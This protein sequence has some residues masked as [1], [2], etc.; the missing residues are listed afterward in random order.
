MDNILSDKITDQAR[1]DAL[2]SEVENATAKGQVTNVIIATVLQWLNGK[3]KSGE[4]DISGALQ[5]LAAYESRLTVLESVCEAMRTGNLSNDIDNLREV[6]AFLAGVK[7]DESLVGLLTAINE[8]VDRSASAEKVDELVG[9]FL[10]LK[11]E[12]TDI[13]IKPFD[14][15]FGDVTSGA[16]SGLPVGTVAYCQTQKA[17]YKATGASPEV[18]A[19]YNVT[20][21]IGSVLHARADVLFRNG[22]D[23]YGY[24]EDTSALEKLGDDTLANQALA[25]ATDTR[26]TM[27]RRTTYIRPQIVP[28][29]ISLGSARGAV[30]RTHVKEIKHPHLNAGVYVE[31]RVPHSFE[32]IVVTDISAMFPDGLPDGTLLQTNGVGT[33]SVSDGKISFDLRDFDKDCANPKW[34][35]R[36]LLPAR[37]VLG[38]KQTL[39]QYIYIDD[40]GALCLADSFNKQL[41]FKPVLF[42]LS[43]KP[44]L[45]DQMASFVGRKGLE[46][47]RIRRVYRRSGKDQPRTADGKRKKYGKHYVWKKYTPTPEQL[48]LLKCG[49]FRVRKVQPRPGGKS[50]WAYF[51]YNGDS[52]RWLVLLN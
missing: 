34:R 37:A 2:I 1:V 51:T 4:A 43:I 45:G 9:D 11:S 22:S 19:G 36:L 29:C 26:D 28:G 42:G 8:R 44:E 49:V 16:F 7:D 23:L 14:T 50:Q 30:Y 5:S 10:G 47:Q 27:Q 13:G 17:F 12:V 52:D 25:M 40:K 6:F 48:S 20:D 24:N 32:N 39:P 31:L 21:A 3:V 35:P 41:T 38:Q 33:I 15:F 46:I 18:P